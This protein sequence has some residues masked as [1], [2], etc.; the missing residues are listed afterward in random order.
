MLDPFDPSVQ[1]ITKRVR[2]RR[3]KVLPSGRI[4]TYYVYVPTW[5]PLIKFVNKTRTISEWR[6]LI[7]AGEDLLKKLPDDLPIT[8]IVM[9]FNKLKRKLAKYPPCKNLLIKDPKAPHN[10]E[11][12]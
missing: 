4:V 10:A 3:K 2:N 8:K 5:Y 11:H 7:A 12:F 9:R 6:L 1:W